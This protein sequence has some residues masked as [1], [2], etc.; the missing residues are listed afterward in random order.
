MAVYINNEPILLKSI[1]EIEVVKNK[2]KHHKANLKYNHIG[3]LTPEGTYKSLLFTDSQIKRGLSRAQRNPE[4]IPESS[5]LSNIFYNFLL[6][7]NEAHTQKIKNQNS[8][9][10]EAEDYNHIAVRL[11]DKTTHLLFTDKEMEVAKKRADRNPEDI[12]TKDSYLQIF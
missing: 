11:N 10:R 8:T 2:D 7:D 1:G 12:P 4:D 3:V 9:K 6:K 5:W